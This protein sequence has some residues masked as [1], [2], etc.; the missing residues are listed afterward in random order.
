M[1]TLE[2]L[3]NLVEKAIHTE[4]SL[5][6]DIRK[7]GIDPDFWY[8][9]ARSHEV[10][11]GKTHPVSFAGVPIVL[12]RP[13]EGELFAL[14]NRCAHRQV[15]LHIGVVEGQT[16][17]CSYHGWTYDETGNCVRVPYLDKCS[18]RPNP[19]RRFPCR[20]AYGL[21]FVFPG[22]PEKVAERVF[23]EIPSASD[24][25]YKTRYLDR[26]VNC[27][28]TFMHENLM[29][30]NHQFLHRR[31]MGGIK[32]ILLEARH[33][34]TWIEVDYTFVRT[35]GK[36]PLGEKFILNQ[37]GKP[38]ENEHDKM[39]IRTDYP[40]QTLRF[41]T[42]GSNEPALDLWNVYVPVDKEQ[43]TNHTYGLMMIR[44]LPIPG[45]IHVLW[46]FIIW[47]TNHIFAEDREICELEQKAFDEQGEDRN[48]EIFPVIRGL[49]SVLV[50]NGIPLNDASSTGA[51]HVSLEQE[52]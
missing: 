45:L 30:M 21:I 9:V 25:N 18:L 43:R 24:S 26:K 47:F 5:R 3:Q 51:A 27:H 12:I 15:P 35:T 38:A 42:A 46:P 8:P 29:D 23:P 11:P 13:K 6:T 28:F 4:A 36:Q 17:K 44:K 14:E 48:H 37:R 7:T 2:D 34:D 31:F 33:G 39:T 49:R 40:Y 10:K 20:E 19:V 1:S 50:E 52:A 41:F 32:T 16:I 22:D